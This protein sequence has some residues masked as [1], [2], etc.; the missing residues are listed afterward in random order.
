LHKI[1]LTIVFLFYQLL[2]LAQQPDLY[3]RKINRQNGL[4][5][6]K[7]NCIIQDKRGFIWIGTDDGLNRYD[8]NNFLI[9]RNTPGLTS[10][11]SGN[12]ITS[13][14]E[15]ENQ[16]LW[17]GTADGGLSRY[18]YRLP[19]EKQFQQYKHNSA[20]SNSIPI[21]IINA[22]VQDREGSL[23]LATSGKRAIRFNKQTGKFEMPAGK[24]TT[25]AIALCIGPEN[26]LWVGRQGGG[27]YTLDLKNL[28]FEHDQRY[29]NL[30]AKLPHA[31]VTS[32]YKDASNNMWFGSWD[33]VLY[34][35]NAATGTEETFQQSS[36]PHSFPNDQVDGFAEDQQGRL[37]MAGRYGGL[38]VLDRKQNSFYNYRLNPAV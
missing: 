20:D 3:F 19:V 13:L 24:G 17:I 22:I 25:T 27:L 11:I 6:N 33:K 36:Q 4:S 35:Y 1:I 32:L 10:C 5:N 31:V 8:G 29:D 38:H 30:Y 16:V 15:D 21:N 9:F 26:K 7:V 34:R 2:V 18:D 14:L 12:I 23:W 37:W 28:A